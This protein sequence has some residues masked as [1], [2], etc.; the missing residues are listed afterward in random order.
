MTTYVT[1]LTDRPVL[2][3]EIVAADAAGEE[4]GASALEVEASEALEEVAVEAKLEASDGAAEDTEVKPL[5]LVD[6][7]PE[8]A[9]ETVAAMGTTREDVSTTD[10]M[11]VGETRLKVARIDDAAELVGTEV[12]TFGT[13]VKDGSTEDGL[14]DVDDARIPEGRAVVV[15]TGAG[16]GSSMAEDVVA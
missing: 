12:A 13:E 10:D 15:V 2:L 14:A 11:L 6:A 9:S 1:G 3:E 16:E 5:A 4:P 8:D 7:L